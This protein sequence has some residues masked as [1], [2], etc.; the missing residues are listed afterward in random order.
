M[1]TMMDFDQSGKMGIEEF[2]LLIADIKKW[3]D[4][5]KYYDRENKGRLNMF[6]LRDALNS[7]GYQINNRI[8]NTLAHRFGSRDGTIGFDD[9]I[10]CAMKMKIIL[11]KYEQHGQNEFSRDDY[12]ER[13]LYT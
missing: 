2:R 11:E 9:F 4:V 7:A 3:R 8:L 12:I 10:M 5:F 13:T 6:E 1:I